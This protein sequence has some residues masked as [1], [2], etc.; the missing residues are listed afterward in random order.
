MCLK[1]KVSFLLMSNAL[2]EQLYVHFRKPKLL[3]C[4]LSAGLVSSAVTGAASGYFKFASKYGAIK[5]ISSHEDFIAQY[6]VADT[7]S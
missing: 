2:R 4:L 5:F 1:S 7:V 6:S 3:Y